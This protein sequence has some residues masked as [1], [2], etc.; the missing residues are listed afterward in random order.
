MHLAMDIIIQHFWKR[1]ADDS[2]LKFTTETWNN[3]VQTPIQLEM[4]F[5]HSES[6]PIHCK[7]FQLVVML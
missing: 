1:N 2:S 3:L 4:D 6:T 5:F 7:L